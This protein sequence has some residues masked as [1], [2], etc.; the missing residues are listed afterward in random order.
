[1][2]GPRGRTARAPE[3]AGRVLCSC[4]TALARGLPAAP[5]GRS[6]LCWHPGHEDRQVGTGWNQR[7]ASLQPS[8]LQGAAPGRSEAS[9]SGLSGSEESV[10]SGLEDSDSDSSEGGATSGTG[11]TAEDPQAGG[12]HSLRMEAAGSTPGQDEYAEDSSD[13]EVGS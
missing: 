11:K 8:L 4:V 3:A 1:M 12:G 10:F 5:G 6:G 7:C 9:D 2:P 13:E